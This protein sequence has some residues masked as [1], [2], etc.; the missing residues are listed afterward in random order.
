LVYAFSLWGQNRAAEA[1]ALF[2]DR[3]QDEPSAFVSAPLIRAVIFAELG[4]TKL[5]RT[6]LA[7]FQRQGALPEEKSLARRVEDE[8]AE[9]ERVT[10]SPVT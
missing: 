1:V 6:S 2:S 5:A 3:S 10:K 7:Q 8:L 4:E 9:Q